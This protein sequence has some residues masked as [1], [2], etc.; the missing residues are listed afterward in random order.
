MSESPSSFDPVWEEIFRAREWGRYPDAHVVRFVARH[1]YARADRRA[2]RLVDIGSGPGASTWYVAREG[3]S[4]A[5][6]DGSPAAIERL[7]QRLTAEAL[8][9][10]LHVG[11]VNRLPWPDAT[12]DGA[13]DNA[14]VCC[15]PFANAVRIVDEVHRVLKPGGAFFSSSFTDRSWGYGLG[16][17]VE[18]GGFT[19]VADG[20]L[21]GKGFTLY[22]GRAQ[23]DEL[24]RRFARVNVERASFTVD[25]MA[26]TVELWNVTAYKAG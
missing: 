2:T 25:D 15:N 26:H 1:F 5:A 19:D 8:D 17:A 9:A 20:P 23:L 3:F 24:Y 21:A 22:L 14:C 11:D 4:V 6:I 16:R 7:R 10:E 12:F 13:I 18:P